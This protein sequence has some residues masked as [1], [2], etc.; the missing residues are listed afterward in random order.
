MDWMRKLAYP[1]PVSRNAKENSAVGDAARNSGGIDAWGY[2]E[3]VPSAAMRQHP[4]RCR[5]GRVALGLSIAAVVA[6][7]AGVAI[8]EV[9][10]DAFAS[11]SQP[12][13]DSEGR[14]ILRGNPHARPSPHHSGGS[15]VNGANEY[16]ASIRHLGPFRI[17]GEWFS[18]GVHVL[19]L[20]AGPDAVAGSCIDPDAGI[21]WHS[22]F[23]GSPLLGSMI[24]LPAGQAGHDAYRGAF[25][26]PLQHYYIN[27]LESGGIGANRDEQL[28]IPTLGR[29]GYTICEDDQ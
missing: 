6:V 20:V 25:T 26:L 18:A 14:Y 17:E 15:S 16:Y 27:R 19:A 2:P 11:A 24:S 4:R 3:D 28:P 8:S 13:Y 12:T 10:R 9:N 22:A 1:W 29:M 7:W 23:I 5:V 21:W